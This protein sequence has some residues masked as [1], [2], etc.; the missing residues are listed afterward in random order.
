MAVIAV[1]A[2][3]TVVV[4][5][6]VTSVAAT[7][8]SVVVSA[9]T[10][11]NPLRTSN[12]PSP[13]SPFPLSP[14][15]FPAPLPRSVPHLTLRE[16]RLASKKQRRPL[17]PCS[18]ELQALITALNAS[19]GVGLNGK[20]AELAGKLEECLKLEGGGK[21]KPPTMYHMM[22]YRSGKK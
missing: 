18:P 7:I 16:L 2:T 10:S 8:I 15:P 21:R 13:F 17:P 20:C 22:K 9:A 6:V 19:E 14:P 1:A 12:P 4:A 5:T 3:S 11:F